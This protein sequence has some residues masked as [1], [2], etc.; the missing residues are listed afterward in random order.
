M[1][2]GYLVKR[3]IDYG[4]AV[5]GLLA[6]GPAMLAIAAIIRL[7]SP[8]GALFQHERVGRGGRPFKM[9]KFRTM[10]AASPVQ[11]NADGSTR[12]AANDPRMTRVGGYLRGAI[13]ELPQLLNVLRGEMSLVGPRPDMP[14]H[15]THYTAEERHKLDVL[16]GVTSLAAVLGRNDVPWK[17]RIAIDLKYI[18]RWSLTLDARI[19]A[20]TVLLPLGVRLSDF[21]DVAAEVL[22]VG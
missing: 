21:R 3:A 2:F 17:R 8:G 20:Q 5:G 10:Y 1:R 9:V 7:D 22:D 13:D 18:E 14:I 19:L 6:L 16:P 12:V 15:V 11:F 4:V